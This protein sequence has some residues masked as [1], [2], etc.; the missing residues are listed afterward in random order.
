M[1]AIFSPLYCRKGASRGDVSEPYQGVHQ[2]KLSWVVQFQA[3]NPF[4]TG[5]H[6][7]FCQLTQLPSVL[8]KGDYVDFS[9]YTSDATR[10][11]KFF[12]I[13]ALL[14]RASIQLRIHAPSSVRFG[15]LIDAVYA[16]G[17]CPHRR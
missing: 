12:S 3:R 13:T 5:K 17:S 2:R 16:G 14:L 9:R 8:R 4:T 1:V 11:C 6:C 15:D 10:G 7:G